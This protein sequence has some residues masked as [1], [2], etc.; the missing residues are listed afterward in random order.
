MTD[1]AA[2]MDPTRILIVG[3]GRMG[4]LIEELA[5]GHGCTVAGVLDVNL[6]ANA[7]ALGEGAWSDVN[8]AIDFTT[9]EAVC[10]HLPRYAALGLNAVIGTDWLECAASCDAGDCRRKQNR[11]C[12]RRQLFDRRGALRECRRLRGGAR[13]V[14]S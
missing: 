7:D 4:R 11:H 8:V 3:Y 9:P 10:Q 2:P 1:L 13:R 6:N 14:A 12:R 5:A